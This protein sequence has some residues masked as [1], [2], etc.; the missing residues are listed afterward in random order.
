MILNMLGG[1]YGYARGLPAVASIT[2]RAFPSA[3][4]ATLAGGAAVVL[5]AYLDRLFAQSAA[6]RDDALLN[7]AMLLCIFVIVASA[8]FAF[9]M[10]IAVA[11]E[12]FEGIGPRGLQDQSRFSRAAKLTGDLFPRFLAMSAVSVPFVAIVIMLY[13]ASGQQTA[14]DI[15]N[16]LATDATLLMRAKL[17]LSHV[18]S[19]S[20]IVV[21]VAGY[22]LLTPVAVLSVTLFGHCLDRL[23]MPVPGNDLIKDA[24][25]R[26]GGFFRSVVSI[27]LMGVALL[28]VAGYVGLPVMLPGFTLK[29]ALTPDSPDGALLSLTLVAGIHLGAIIAGASVSAVWLLA[30]ED[31]KDW[32]AKNPH[33]MDATY[34]H[35]GQ[36]Y[37]ILPKRRIPGW[38]ILLW[39]FAVLTIPVL[40]FSIVLFGLLWWTRDRKPEPQFAPMGRDGA[41]EFERARATL[42]RQVGERVAPDTANRSRGGGRKTAANPG[43]QPGDA[44]VNRPRGPW[45]KTAGITAHDLPGSRPVVDRVRR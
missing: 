16:M 6:G 9:N 18:F 23:D 43:F 28:G 22:M 41:A 25:R 29:A 31:A 33:S 24:V 42:M 13:A 34:E 11:A 20:A 38:R 30:R 27:P 3:L 2:A 37:A 39:I 7:L 44:P 40:P 26:R 21:L 4:P 12:Q 19:L 8:F 5:G 45:Q 17:M 35:D 36:V 10:A 14:K 15:G 32:L 1:L